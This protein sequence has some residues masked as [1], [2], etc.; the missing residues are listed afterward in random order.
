MW[1]KRTHLYAPIGAG[2]FVF[3][4]FRFIHSV[5][6]NHPTRAKVNEISRASC[7][8]DIN[9]IFEGRVDSNKACDCLLPAYAEI[10]KNDS[11]ELTRYSQGAVDSLSASVKDTL[12]TLF[13][14]CVTPYVLDSTFKMHLTGSS[15]ARIK[16]RLAAKLRSNPK[17]DGTNTDSLASILADRLNGNITILQFLGV[18][19]LDDSS[20]QR[21]TTPNPPQK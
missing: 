9:A 21:L 16:S 11:E 8:S 17:F 19:E 12:Y 7:L 14:H 15:L 2:L 13:T 18:R 4:C 1:N 20:M 3:L 6:N 10:F 5:S